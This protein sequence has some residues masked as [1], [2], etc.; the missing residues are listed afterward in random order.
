MS[1]PVNFLFLCLGLLLLQQ[2]LCIIGIAQ[3]WQELGNTQRL[4]FGAALL[5]GVGHSVLLLV[6][7]PRALRWRPRR[8][9]RVHPEMLR[10]RRRIA[11]ELHDRVGAQLVNALAL[12]NPADANHSAQRAILEHGLLE[13]RLL[14]DGMDDPEGTLADHLSQL[15]YRVQPVLEHHGISLEWDAYAAS[16]PGAPDSVLLARVAQEALSNVVQH[17]Q[18]NHVKVSVTRT[19]VPGSWH[20][21]ISDNGRGMPQAQGRGGNG[22]KGMQE[23]LQQAGGQLQISHPVLGGTCVSATVPDPA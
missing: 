2:V 18:A 6:Q 14:V 20:I 1:R 19:E 16:L 3:V 12:V 22:L 7:L 4:V 9:Q 17:A 23:R 13:L 21:E 8:G 15:R 5:V 10:E 11:R